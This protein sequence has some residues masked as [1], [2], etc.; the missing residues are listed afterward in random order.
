MFFGAKEPSA[1]LH[2]K[3]QRF[4]EPMKFLPV[5]FMCG[6]IFF[7]YLVYMF[8]HC[9]P[10]L[11]MGVDPEHVDGVVR[12]AAKTE[13]IACNVITAMMV[14]CYLRAMFTSPGTVPTGDK[15]WEYNEVMS[16]IPSFLVETKK[17]GDRRHCKWCGK[18]KPDRCHHCR[19]CKTCVLKMDHHC[20]WIYN[21][22]GH[23]NYKFFFLLLFYSMLDLILIAI[24]M[25]QSVDKVIELETPFFTMFIILFAET[26]AVFLGMLVGMF[27]LFHIW[28]VFN[29]MTTIEFCE[30]NLPKKES[31]RSKDESMYSMGFY[32]NITAT[33]GDN[34]LLWLLPFGG[35][36]GDGLRYNSTGVRTDNLDATKQMQRLHDRTDMGCDDYDAS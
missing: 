21:C 5:F 24:T 12:S 10:R 8:E 18:Y 32:G 36:S 22:V 4:T 30:K 3:P 13:I 11:Q 26:I 16:F 25:A 31:D 33:L 20:P 23:F 15:H 29:A 9:V 34:P 7:M 2:P 6:T 14:L 27:F 28:L 19:V 1:P 17:T 35:P